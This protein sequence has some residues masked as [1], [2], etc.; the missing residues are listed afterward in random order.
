MTTTTLNA[1]ARPPIAARA[2]VILALTGSTLGV[3]AGIVEL[4]VGPAIRSWTGDKHDTTRLGLATIALSA[5]ALTSALALTRRRP[6]SASRVAVVALGLVAPAAICFTTAGPL[7]Y[8]PGTLLIT[9]GTLTIAGVRH[10]TAYIVAAAERNWTAIL[11]ATLAVIYLALGIAAQGTPG[12]LGIIGGLATLALLA[13]RGRIPLPLA[14]RI[15][16]LAVA[17]FA[18]MT[19]WSLVTPVIAVLIIV[20]GASALAP[21]TPP[22]MP[23]R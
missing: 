17:P 21:S 7:W 9:S 19:W 3:L 20:I 5:I 10:H 16:L 14:L 1:P 2:A 8:L 13:G 22:P 23:P 11:T 12:A 15:L 6:H 18:L 4:T